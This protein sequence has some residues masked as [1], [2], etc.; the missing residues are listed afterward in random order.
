[1]SSGSSMQ[2]SFGDV[3]LQSNAYFFSLSVMLWSFGANAQGPALTALAQQ[4]SPPGAE[5]TSLSLVKAAGDGTYILH[6]RS[7]SSGFD[8]RF[9]CRS[10]WR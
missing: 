9:L 6:H 2:V 5:A 1:M 7:F 4:Y 8:C 3:V 10:P